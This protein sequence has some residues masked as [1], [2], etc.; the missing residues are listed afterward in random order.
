MWQVFRHLPTSTRVVDDF[1]RH[2]DDGCDWR[3]PGGTC[4]VP[5][6][7]RVQGREQAH[8]AED[9]AAAEAAEAEMPGRMGMAL[10]FA[11]VGVAKVVEKVL[12]PIER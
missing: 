11:I 4:R 12:G 7:G 3:E 2:S 5:M 10:V 9:A 1:K 6:C 8:A